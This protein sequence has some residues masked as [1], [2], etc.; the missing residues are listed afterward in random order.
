MK[1]SQITLLTFCL[2]YINV[3]YAQP[4][5]FSDT[6]GMYVNDFKLIVGNL[7]EEDELLDYAQD[8]G[9]NYLILYN[10]YYINNNLFEITDASASLPLSDFIYKAKTMY[11]I[12]S[13]AGVGEK[14]TSFNTIHAYNQ[15][16]LGEPLKQLDVYN[17]EFEFWNNGTT[18]P[19]GYYCTTYLTPNG[20]PCDTANAFDFYLEE[21]C[22]LDSLCDEHS[23]VSSETYIGNPTSGQCTALN[24]CADRVLVHYY[25][26][27]DVYGDGTSIYNYKSYRLPALA[28]SDSFSNVMPIF[29]CTEEFMGEWLETN[30][31]NQAFDTWLTGTDGYD[32]DIGPWKSNTCVEGS[33]WFKYTCMNNEALITN[34][35]DK[36][37]ADEL[38]I[39]PNPTTG[40]IELFGSYSDDV[41][42]TVSDLSGNLA[43]SIVQ[44]G[45]IQMNLSSLPDGAYMVQIK[46]GES[47]INRL[48]LKQ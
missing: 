5:C 1:F 17:M 7:A 3:L 28:A 13:I 14:F 27:S 29:A 47:A 40:K 8:N 43:R 30:P 15:L 36:K 32:S 4:P 12:H 26:S 39:Y 31:H 41:Q 9:F 48:V 46:T 25:R 24:N 6:K 42:I 44:T 22:R 10:L 18:G 23:Y 34:I 19:G 16:H 37:E 45:K 20:L 33:V 2:F 38:Q 35:S 21:M 11:G